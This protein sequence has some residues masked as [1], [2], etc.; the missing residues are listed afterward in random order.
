MYLPAG[1]RAVSFCFQITEAEELAIDEAV[2]SVV[3][4]HSANP[5]LA[6]SPRSSQAI[7]PVAGASTSSAAPAT[8]VVDLVLLDTDS[9]PDDADSLCEFEFSD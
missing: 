1:T 2:G 5:L 3:G 8:P 9:E 7:L 4:Y 6:R